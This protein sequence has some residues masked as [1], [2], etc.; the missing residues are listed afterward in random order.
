MAAM[1]NTKRTAIEEQLFGQSYGVPNHFWPYE[2]LGR[3]NYG[4]VVKASDTKK[5]RQVAVKQVKCQTTAQRNMTL[6]EVNAMKSGKHPNLVA[7]YGLYHV[8]STAWLVMECIEGV[9]VKQL[10][11]TMNQFG[12]SQIAYV[13]REVLQ[14]LHFLHSELDIIHRDVKPENILISYDGDVKLADL[15]LSTKASKKQGQR[16]GTPPYMAPSVLRD[17]CY[18]HTVDIWSLGMTIY[19]MNERRAPYL[20]LCNTAEELYKIIVEN[21]HTPQLSPCSQEMDHFYQSVTKFYLHMT[22]SK[23]LKHHWLLTAVKKTEFS[24]AMRKAFFKS[25]FTNEQYINYMA[26]ITLPQ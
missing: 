8:D 19:A 10:L 20:G 14:A 12:P 23:L 24:S 11:Q 22:T 21:L 13:T 17:P 1:D 26:G 6:N 9:N 15:G 16:V 4:T 5:H 25:S 3:G 18:D 2:E 7:F